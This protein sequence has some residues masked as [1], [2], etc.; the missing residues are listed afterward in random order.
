MEF[1][2]LDV[3]K[4]TWSIVKGTDAYIG[5]RGGGAFVAAGNATTHI[6]AANYAG[7]TTGA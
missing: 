5:L 1:G 2:N 7:S 4:G 3:W 6:V